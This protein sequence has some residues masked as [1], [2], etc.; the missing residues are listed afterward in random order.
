MTPERYKK[1]KACLLR[2]QLTLTVVMEN[3]QKS[4]NFAAI[5]RSCDAVGISDA[6]AITDNGQL[7][8]HHMTAAGAH[9]WVNIHNH[10][11]IS[12]PLTEL[13]QKGF[14]IL[15]AHPASNSAD[16]RAA[17]YTRPTAVVMGS[18]LY[19]ISKQTLENA[20]QCLKIPM[21]GLVESFNVS[22]AAALILYEAQR[23]REASGLYQTPQI[24]DKQLTQTLFKWC[25]PDIAN[26][27]QK[28]NLP[29]PELDDGGYIVGKLQ[30][31][32]LQP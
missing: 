17:D 29:Y 7:P 18:E 20:D 28:H 4:R 31:T 21:Q 22:V 1:L 14:Q 11:D 27:C 9:K 3:V 8:R 26:Y 13:R 25:Y 5:I 12:I 10:S 6:Y 30:D 24:S 32:M 15:A 16:F 2:R 23:Q 19:G